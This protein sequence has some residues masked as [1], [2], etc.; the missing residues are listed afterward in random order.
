M[1]FLLLVLISALTSCTVQTYPIPELDT[2]GDVYKTEGE[3]DPLIYTPTTGTKK[4]VMVFADFKDSKAKEL[5]E[6][7][8]K[9]VLGNGLFQKLFHDQSYGKLKLD[10]EQ[11][12]GWRTLP[13]SFKEFNCAKTETHRD[14]FVEVFAMYPDVNF[15]EYDYIMVCMTRLGNYAFGERDAL[16]IPYKGEKINDEMSI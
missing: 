6:E 12:H 4:A 14:L 13:K 9:A 2:K 8:A 3:N 7:R 10:I 1:R 16:A 11:I 15:L 5:T